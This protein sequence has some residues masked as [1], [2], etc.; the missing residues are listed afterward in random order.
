VELGDV[1]NGW[2]GSLPDLDVGD[3]DG[4]LGVLAAAV[5]WIA[6]GIL[7]VFVLWGLLNVFLAVLLTVVAGLYWIFYRALRQILARGRRCRGNL[8]LSMAYAAFFTLLYTG[9]LFGVL[10]GG[11]WLV[12]AKSPG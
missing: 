3:A 1:G 10:A 8:G 11:A 12:G 6:V 9:W 2:D 4:C 5:L 7:L